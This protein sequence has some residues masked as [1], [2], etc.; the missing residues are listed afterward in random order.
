[1]K[2]TLLSEEAMYE[3]AAVLA[4]A[5]MPGLSIGL[6][7]D[8]GAGKTAFCRG[9]LRALGIKGIV[10]SPTYTFVEPYETSLC[11]VFHF[12]LYR[13]GDARKWYEMGFDEYRQFDSLCLIEWPE[14]AALKDLDLY[15][16]IE[17]PGEGR[18]I[19]VVAHTPLGEKVLQRE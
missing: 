14:K 13:L 16:H 9:F 18:V 15:V 6:I 2:K 3:C 11:R 7:G 1:M 8:L 5:S 17:I 4:A 12:D 10:K 19:E